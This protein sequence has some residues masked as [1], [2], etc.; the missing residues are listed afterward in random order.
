VFGYLKYKTLHTAV[1]SGVLGK[2]NFGG[3]FSQEAKRITT[4]I[5]EQS[6]K[7][8]INFVLFFFVSLLSYHFS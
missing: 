6:M 2:K 5:F 4:A 1:E 8:D 7:A 3:N